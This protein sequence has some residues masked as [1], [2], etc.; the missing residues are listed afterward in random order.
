[1][2]KI[3]VVYA[4]AGIGHKKAAVAVK[5]ALDEVRPQDT[6]VSLID[7]LD[8][9]NAFFKWTYLKVYLLAV[10]KLSLLWGFMYY[11][12]DNYYV[13]L[14][15]SKLRRL[16]NWANSKP[17][18]THLLKNQPEVIVSTHFFAS[19][20]ASDLKRAGLLRSKIITVITDYRLHSWWVSDFVDIYV[21]SNEE[22]RDDLMRW[23]IA[24][25]K[26]KVL[27]IPVEPVFSKALDK[28]KIKSTFEL[29]SDIFTVLVIGGGFGV[30]PIEDIV[31]SAAAVPGPIQ[32]IV[33]CGH[34]EDLINRMKSLKERMGI[35]LKV[36]GF[37]DNVY[38]FM[39]VSDIVISKAGGITVTECLAKGLPL[40]ATSPIPG[41]ETGNSDFVVKH[42]AAIRIKD[43]RDI[44]AILED[45]MADPGRMKAMRE[46][47]RRLGRP[48]ACYDVAA[49]A[50]GMAGGRDA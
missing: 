30:G 31:K 19:E 43:V 9:T 25:S 35:D 26:I 37:V 7:A 11:L 42:G 21:V 17:L 23:G 4:T 38:D 8:Y 1:M 50:A 6:E 33:I 40:I 39:E 16:N 41:Q 47:V 12:T 48:R 10:N 18:V 13:N 15:V 5:K 29:K 32:V 46:T 3:L 45:L 28:E 2:K 49:L 34:N 36:L 44:S 22:A 24:D 14:A 27:G 20:V